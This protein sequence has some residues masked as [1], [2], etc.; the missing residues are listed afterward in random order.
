MYFTQFRLELR[1]VRRHVHDA[2]LAAE[3]FAE[4]ERLEAVGQ[5]RVFVSPVYA[6]QGRR[7]FEVYQEADSDGSLSLRWWLALW[8]AEH[9]ANQVRQETPSPQD[10]QAFDLAL[11]F[12]HD[13]EAATTAYVALM[14]LQARG[15]VDVYLPAGWSVTGRRDFNVF[16]NVHRERLTLKEWA[17]RWYDE[18]GCVE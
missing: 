7:R 6:L 13:A 16:D 8:Q 12:P 14:E 3:A 4:L 1:D 9:L 2:Q 17:T 11:H 18:N 10:V 15:L 5:V